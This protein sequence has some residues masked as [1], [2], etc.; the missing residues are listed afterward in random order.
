M[1]T[2]GNRDCHSNNLLR[3]EAKTTFELKWQAFDL[4]CKRLAKCASTSSPTHMCEHVT[5]FFFR[6][7]DSLKR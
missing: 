5:C 3:K 1:G 4:A 7:M 6:K 2:S